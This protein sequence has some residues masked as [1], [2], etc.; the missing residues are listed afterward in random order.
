M[1]VDVVAEM[2]RSSTTPA[3]QPGKEHGLYR[4]TDRQGMGR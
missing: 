2:S 4:F 3:Q 1:S